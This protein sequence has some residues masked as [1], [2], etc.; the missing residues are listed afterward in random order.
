[1]ETMTIE[2]PLEQGG[3]ADSGPSRQAQADAANRAT[4]E[5]TFDAIEARERAVERQ[6]VIHDAFR[7]NAETDR[8]IAEWTDYRVEGLEPYQGSPATI[9]DSLNAAADR[10]FARERAAE[11]KRMPELAGE[12]TLAERLEASQK[13]A[14]LSDENKRLFKAGHVE[15][16]SLRDEASWFGLSLQEAQA[17]KLEARLAAQDQV[18]PVLDRYAKLIPNQRP[19]QTMANAAAWAEAL[20]NN[21]RE[22]Y[23]Q[24][25]E[26][27][28]LGP[29]DLQ[30]QQAQQQQLQIQRQ[31]Q[32]A[33]YQQRAAAARQGAMERAVSTTIDSF[34]QSHPDV[35]GLQDRIVHALRSGAVPRGGSVMQ[36]LAAA[37]RFAGGRYAV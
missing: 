15:A 34:A 5:R 33:Q 36:R 10:A 3:S 37:Y 21:P 6:P 1:M 22:A 16:Q 25:G 14:E 9:T 27:L 32:A 31:Q 24:L 35:D 13:W 28:G 18:R 29:I 19:E 30:Q 20:R 26:R 23:R 12:K 7:K 11:A 2:R 4:L 17:A 8:V